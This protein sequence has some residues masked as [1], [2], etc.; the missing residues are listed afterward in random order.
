MRDLETDL[1]P[2]SS[3]PRPSL[4]GVLGV[5]DVAVEGLALF[6]IGGSFRGVSGGGSSSTGAGV[7]APR[8]PSGSLSVSTDSRR[9][10]GATVLR[11][12]RRPPG[13]FT[14][15]LRVGTDCEVEVL[16]AESNG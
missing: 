9:L 13:D 16:V 4:P 12:V 10:D 7:D 2:S 3:T 11:V 5:C 8:G 14:E 15:G 1:L 6:A